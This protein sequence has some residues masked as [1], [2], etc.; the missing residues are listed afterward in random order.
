MGQDMIVET[1]SH[2]LGAKCSALCSFLLW[3]TGVANE[4]MP[5]VKWLSFF[6]AGAA[7]IVSIYLGMRSLRKK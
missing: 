7:S 3:T 2:A 1:T 6:L 4:T 5:L